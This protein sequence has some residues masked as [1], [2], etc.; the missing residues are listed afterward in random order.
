MNEQF[1]LERLKR[2]EEKK[3]QTGN[4]NIKHLKNYS[5]SFVEIFNF[6]L[7][8]YRKDILNFC[9]SNINIQLDLTKEDGMLCFKKFDDGH[10]KNMDIIYT[11]HPNILR[12]IITSKKSMGLFWGEWTTGISECLFTEDE[13]L[14]QFLN[15]NIKIP[16]PFLKEFKN[17]LIKKKF[18]IMENFL[19]DLKNR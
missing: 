1:K 5:K 10:Y 18:I 12:A 16:E 19:N 7:K 2:I 11:K 6:F 17:L 9:G 14:S 15:N 4:R 13:I 3:I 8:S